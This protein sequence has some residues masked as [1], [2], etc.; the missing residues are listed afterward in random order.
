MENSNTCG[1][2]WVRCVVVNDELGELSGYL[3][4][5]ILI[6]IEQSGTKQGGRGTGAGASKYL[7]IN[8]RSS[9]RDGDRDTY[10]KY[11]NHRTSFPF[12]IS[13]F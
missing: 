6:L 13:Q 2:F 8:I 9:R 1:L 10:A 5:L 4:R 7:Y 11:R 12:P 3:G